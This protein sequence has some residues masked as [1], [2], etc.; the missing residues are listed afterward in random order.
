ML[1][2]IR[3]NPSKYLWSANDK[4]KLL[5]Y[6][7]M[8]SRERGFK[9]EEDILYDKIETI[10]LPKVYGSGF[11]PHMIFEPLF[12]FNASS[13]QWEWPKSILITKRKVSKVKEIQIQESC[14]GW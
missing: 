10:C 13:E 8:H 3:K 14:D 7:N 1:E 9:E 2:M 12:K 11:L 6:Y 4:A 5:G